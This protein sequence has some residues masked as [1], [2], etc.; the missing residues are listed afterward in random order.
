MKSRTTSRT[1][2][3]GNFRRRRSGWR[4]RLCKCCAALGWRKGRDATVAL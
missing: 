1:S 3:I 2:A 4:S